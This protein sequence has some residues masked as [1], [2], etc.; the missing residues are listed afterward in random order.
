MLKSPVAVFEYG[1]RRSDPL[2]KIYDADNRDNKRILDAMTG[3]FFP[4]DNILSVMTVHYGMLSDE[5][6]TRVFIMERPQFKGF[7]GKN[8]QRKHAVSPL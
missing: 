4:D 5:E 7:I 6:Y 8:S 3:T 1:F 2:S